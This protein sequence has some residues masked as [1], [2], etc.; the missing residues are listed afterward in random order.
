MAE[1]SVFDYTDYRKY[2]KDYYTRRKE[3]LSHFSHRFIA[4]KVGFK[5][6]G[7]FSQILSGKANISIVLIE[8]ISSFLEHNN[9]E[10]SFFQNMILYNQAKE[11]EVK[12]KYF[13]KMLSY[14]EAKIRQIDTQQYGLYD[15]WFFTAVREL[16]AFFP[17][18]GDFDILADMII[19]PITKNQAQ[20]AI[21]ALEQLHLIQRLDTGEY[22]VTDELITTGK[23]S[24]PVRLNNYAID[25][26]ALASRAIERFPK[27]LRNVSWVTMSI[28]PQTCKQIIEELRSLRQK[29]MELAMAD[30]SPDRVYQLNL[31]LFPL[32]RDYS[33]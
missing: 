16:I 21:L 29:V 31:Q 12:H 19:P 22:K 3:V 15:H 14:K 13:E 9:R 30:Q 10:S 28:S 6:G 2:L 5:S 11:P 23:H 26:I 20:E 24:E 33:E 25:M 27:S 7:H 17:F 1:I 4:Q 18:H 32:S 8:K